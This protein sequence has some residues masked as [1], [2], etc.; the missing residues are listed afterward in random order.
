MK[1]AIE[2]LRSEDEDVR[3]EAKES[4]LQI[5]SSLEACSKDEIV[6]LL[7][8]EHSYVRLTAASILGEWSPLDESALETLVSLLG[9]E[10]EEVKRESACALARHGAY[11]S[12]DVLWSIIG[13]LR[14]HYASSAAQL[15]LDEIRCSLST[16]L[17]ES[18]A[19]RAQD[20]TGEMKNLVAVFLTTIGHESLVS[21]YLSDIV[22][23]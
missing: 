18:I 15:V 13:F 1:A 10:S 8:D 23:A 11:L 22:D 6:A 20:E 21:T 2:R 9:D 17:L 7:R 12:A 4:L 3:C 5:S 19:Q 16:H 14:T